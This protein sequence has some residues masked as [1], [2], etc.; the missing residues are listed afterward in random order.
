MIEAHTLD[1]WTR[2]SSR[3]GRPFGY[4]SILGG[5]AGAAVS[6]AGG[7]WRGCRPGPVAPPG[8]RPARRCRD[9]CRRGLE[10]FVLAFLF[11]LQAFMVSPGSYPVTLFRVDILNIMGPAI[12]ASGIVWCGPPGLTA[13]TLVVGVRR[14]RVRGGDGHAARAD[15]AAGRQAAHLDAV[16]Y[17]AAGDYTTFT[18]FPWAGFVFAGAACGV[19]LARDGDRTAARPRL[20]FAV[21]G[22]A[23]LAL[24][25]VTAARPSIYAQSSFWTSS[26]TYFAIRVGILMLGLAVLAL[27]AGAT[28]RVASSGS[29][30]I[31]SGEAR[32]SSTGSTSSWSTATPRG[33]SGIGCR[34]GAPRSPSPF[35]AR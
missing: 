22:A 25:F 11:R 16:V 1:A 33:R 19:L 6:L 15:L 9:I 29:C 10:I 21:A 20:S 17:P 31:V 3:T 24:G 27:M 18:L 23:V 32:C 13:G 30:W 35:S 12:V 5:F 4:A 26:P 2:W 8:E 28:E 14:T 34:C 7:D